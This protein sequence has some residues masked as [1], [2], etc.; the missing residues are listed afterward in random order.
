ME[1]D[2]A[3]N[4]ENSARAADQKFCFSCGATL[5]F[6]AGNCP[7]CGAAQPLSNNVIQPAQPIASAF[8]ANPPP[9]HVFCRGCGS[10]I[11]ESAHTC[12]KCGAVLSA[13]GS[14]SKIAAGVLALFLGGLGVHKFYLGKSGMGVLYLL[15]CW[16][17]IPAIVGLIEGIGYLCMSDEKF[18]RE[19][20]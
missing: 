2:M 13:S 20:G 5:H 14:K 12:P 6:S 1:P 9:N 11:H 16:T 10:P 3:N 17:W 15:F 7:R 19:Y 8:S 18:H 4:A